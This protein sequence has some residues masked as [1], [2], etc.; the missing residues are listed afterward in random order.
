MSDA[1]KMVTLCDWNAT[2]RSICAMN[3]A[4]LSSTESGKKRLRHCFPN[5]NVGVEVMGHFVD[6]HRVV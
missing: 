2:S 1:L 6:A 3:I 5:D 4:T